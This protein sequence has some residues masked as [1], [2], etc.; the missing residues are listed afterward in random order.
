MKRKV[1]LLSGKKQVGKDTFASIICA[2]K[3]HPF[4]ATALA[5]ELKDQVLYM[6]TQVLGIP[7]QYMQ[8]CLHKPELKEKILCTQNFRDSGK[9]CTARSLMQWY[10]Q[11][12]K[13]AFDELF[14]VNTLL[15]H[16][17]FD[18]LCTYHIIITDCRFKYELEELKSRLKDRFD[19][20]TV[21][22][23]RK[24]SLLDSDI[25][26]TDLD[27]VDDFTLIMS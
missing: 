10:G 1:I 14:W 3:K 4:F 15:K 21:R 19:V 16:W 12:I 17:V 22:I 6:G 8:D 24:A 25:S 7:K 13:T 11:M 27:L 26:E 2:N 9:P 18:D 23:K 20:V 5:T